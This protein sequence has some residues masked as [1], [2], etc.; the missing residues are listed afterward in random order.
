MAWKQAQ[1]ERSTGLVMREGVGGGR[2][3]VM[4]GQEALILKMTCLK[5]RPQLAN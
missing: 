1:E 3:V 2:L 4:T 5:I